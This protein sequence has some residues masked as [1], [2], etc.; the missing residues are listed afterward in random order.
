MRIN[1]VSDVHGATE[2]LALAAD[3]SDVFICL[4]DLLLYLDYDD[5][6]VGAFAEVYG[7]DVAREYI[8]LRLHH[9]FADARQLTQDAWQARHGGDDAQRMMVMGGV[10]KR[11]YAE[12]FEKM[13]TGAYFTF[14]NVDVP[15]L[16]LPFVRSDQHC[17]DAE[18]VEISGA[19]FGFV[20]GGL[21]SP[22]RT[23]N[24]LTIEDFAARVGALGSADVLC[25]HIPPL[26][27]DLTYD[28]VARRFEVGS[29]AI[30]E[31]INDVQPR[32]AL[33]GH[34][35]QPLASRFRIGRTECINVGHFRSRRIPFV[36]D[37]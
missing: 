27:A 22:Y 26:I 1:L 10:I 24:E 21:K 18:V 8:E 30:L 9:R 35:H 29:R 19:R 34:V 11:Q 20:G 6:A 14:G 15:A 13:P 33:F 31:Y 23:P 4:G 28:V 5:P 3:G 37:L 12:I 36:L 17:V 16:A 7:A 32:Y 2:A 25:S